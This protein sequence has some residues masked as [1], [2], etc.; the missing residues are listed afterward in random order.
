MPEGVDGTNKELFGRLLLVKVK[1]VTT[2]PWKNAQTAK[3][4][5]SV[6]AIHMGTLALDVNFSTYH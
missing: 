5:A 1:P 4:P 2:N 3:N 6:D